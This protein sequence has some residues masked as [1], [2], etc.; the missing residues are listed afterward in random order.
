MKVV[1]GLLLACAS[2]Y[3][4]AYFIDKYIKASEWGVLA[5]GIWLMVLGAAVVFVV[6][7]SDS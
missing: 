6:F 7:S 3:G 1:L 5:V 4:G 2:V